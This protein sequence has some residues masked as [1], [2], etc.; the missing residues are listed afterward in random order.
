MKA[1]AGL[2][3]REDGVRSDAS[4]REERGRGARG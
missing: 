3:R 1:M 2:G 4:K